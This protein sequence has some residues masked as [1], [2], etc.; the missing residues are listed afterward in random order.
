[1]TDSKGIPA[2]SGVVLAGGASS[3]MGRDKALIEVAGVPMVLRVARTMAAAGASRI[4]VAGGDTVRLASLGLTVVPDRERG[5]GPLAGILAAM[6]ELDVAGSES[7]SPTQGP[8]MVTSPCDTPLLS[9]GLISGLV[10]VLGDHPNSAV[11]V[12][13]G[14]SGLEPLLAAWRIRRCRDAVADRLGS[15][16]LSV[17]GVFDIV[18]TT[19]MACPDPVQLTNVNT[20]A[21]LGA[22]GDGPGSPE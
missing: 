16:S 5:L 22:L 20:P 4:L 19:T 2:F 14:P 1:M 12:A 13:E 7:P 18:A 11:V 21:D 6:G 3:R 15:G 17:R 8:I 9:A 10:R